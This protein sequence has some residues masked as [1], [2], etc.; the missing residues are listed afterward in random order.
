MKLVQ[1]HESTPARELLQGLDASHDYVRPWWENPNFGSDESKE[2]LPAGRFG[3]RPS[4]HQLPSSLLSKD[5]E[6][7]S[8]PPLLY[9]I[10]AVL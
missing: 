2:I 4:M 8:G 7:N 3:V 5:S 9:N 10:C 1:N 6:S